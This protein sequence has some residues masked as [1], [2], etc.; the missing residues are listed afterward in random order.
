M[1]LNGVAQNNDFLNV[2]EKRIIELEKI[3]ES[4]DI[5]LRVANLKSTLKINEEWRQLILKNMIRGKK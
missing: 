1:A 4:E 5:P 3:L 2:V